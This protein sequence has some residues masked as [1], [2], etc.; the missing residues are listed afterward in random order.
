[1]IIHSALCFLGIRLI[2]RSNPV[3]STIDEATFD[4]K[5]GA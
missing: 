4:T 2:F 1:M 3:A 5:D